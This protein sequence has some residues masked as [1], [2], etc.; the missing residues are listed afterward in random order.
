MKKKIL[1][2]DDK[3]ELRMLIKLYLS[4]NYEVETAENGL[5]ALAQML[6][7][8]VPDLILTDMMMPVVGGRELVAQLKNSGMFD[9]IPVIILSS[10][11]KSEDRIAM[12]RGGAGDYLIKPFNPEEL[13]A[14]IENACK[15]NN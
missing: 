3:K 12:L 11:D 4:N 7:G 9:H 2:V 10:I 15:S 13:L 5:D 6:K 14:R 8:Y 1:V